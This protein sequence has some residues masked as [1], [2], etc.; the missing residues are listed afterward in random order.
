[1]ASISR[2]ILCLYLLLCFSLIHAELRIKITKPSF[3]KRL[4]QR[5]L[6]SNQDDLPLQNFEDTQYNT[7]V[8]IGSN[9]QVFNVQVDTGS[10]WLWVTS[11][12]QIGDQ[13]T[14]NKFICSSSET[15]QLTTKTVNIEY[16]TGTANGSVF[17]DTLNLGN[18]FKVSNQAMVLINDAE[19]FENYTADGLIG[20]GFKSLSDGVPT[21]LDNLKSQGVVAKREF[22]M[23]LSFDPNG[24]DVNG[25]LVIGGSDPQHMT[26]QSF[27]YYPVISD[28]YWAVELRSV[29]IGGI[30]T[31]YP[32]VQEAV[33]DSGTSV[34]IVGQ[35]DWPYFKDAIRSVDSS[36]VYSSSTGYLTCNC[37]SETSISNYPTL[38]FKFGGKLLSQSYDI[39]PD[40]YI[41]YQD[42]ACYI[43]VSELDGTDFW[44]LGDT[45][46]V[47]YYTDFDEDNM[48][49]GFMKTSTTGSPKLLLNMILG[50]LVFIVMSIF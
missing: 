29:A 36:C 32:T 38:S 3:K 7:N 47:N 27:D 46:M 22:S 35:Q 49:I 44:I 20:L 10:S 41:A 19:D 37:G 13:F 48:E 6:T 50:T 17:T 33:I 30:T 21:F 25:E 31:I 1:M 45:F 39:T 18:G 8:S 34:I 42:G 43:L 9:G 4:L 28:Q 5:I 24:V 23:F 11:A 16:G 15:C 2:V 12:N 14:N 40:Q 26:Q